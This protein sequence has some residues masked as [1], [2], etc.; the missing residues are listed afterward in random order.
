[1]ARIGKIA[2]LPGDIR[3]QL[4]SRLHEGAEG[5]SLLQWL[6]SL[7]HV[8]SVLAEHF[9]ACPITE[10][11]LSDWRQGGYQDWLVH[12]DILA[13]A[14]DLAATQHDLPS[15]VQSQSIADHFATAV[16]FRCSAILAAHGSDLDDPAL[17][18][19]RALSHTCQAAV[20][21]RQ[22]N[23]DAA[24][25][26]IET[27]RWERVRQQMDEDRAQALQQR[28]SDALAAPI[29]AALKKGERV[30]QFGAGPGALLAADLLEEIETCQDPAHFQ[31]K[32]ISKLAQTDW[33][34]TL[35]SQPVAPPN[36]IE[37]VIEDIE[38][39]DSYLERKHRD[40]DIENV[41]KKH[42]R[43]QKPRRRSHKVR[44]AKGRKAS[45]RRPGPSPARSSTHPKSPVAPK[46]LDCGGPTPLSSTETSTPSTPSTSSTS[47]IPPGAPLPQTTPNPG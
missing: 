44:P 42:R 45:P 9:D 13:Q 21:L 36:P 14:R 31:S 41:L 10:Q 8:H 24:R 25:L 12:Q 27:E 33:R 35:S 11:N 18:Q 29:W 34:K 46:V 6:N 43:R 37:S 5:K 30:A 1:M 40:L 7:P 22:S 23:Q 15:A 38:K 3:T 26:Q 2:R 19:L 47:S 16:A 17:R 39:M 20:K 4:N 28:Q 32:V